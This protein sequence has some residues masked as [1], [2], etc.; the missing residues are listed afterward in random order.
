VGPTGAT[1]I[2]TLEIIGN[3]FGTGN[4]SSRADTPYFRI[5][6]LSAGWNGCWTGDPGTDSVTCNIPSWTN[7]TIIFGGF[8][9]GYGQNGWVINDGDRVEIQVWNPQSGKGPATCQIIAGNS[10][11]T[12]C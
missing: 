5:S 9:G 1:D 12:N 2:T 4:T 10:S 8:T 6:D 3:C 7:T 11:A